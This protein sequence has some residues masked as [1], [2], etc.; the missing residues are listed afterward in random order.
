MI[1]GQGV[2]TIGKALNFWLTQN[3]SP[4]IHTL[5]SPA[6][7]FDL[8]APTELQGKVIGFIEDRTAVSHPHPVALPERSIW[9]WKTAAMVD[10]AS[11]THRERKRNYGNPR[12]SQ[13]HKSHYRASSTYQHQL[14]L[15]R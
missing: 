9:E 2:G 1:Q 6:K 4:F 14:L 3:K 11:S 5:H 7:F 10:N 13:G 12:G 15:M 8:D